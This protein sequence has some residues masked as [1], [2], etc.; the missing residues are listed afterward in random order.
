MGPKKWDKKRLAVERIDK[1]NTWNGHIRSSWNVRNTS[2]GRKSIC[3]C[4]CGD[5]NITRI[6]MSNAFG[7]E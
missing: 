2:V 7:N 5:F 4:C 1:R 6:Y 3:L